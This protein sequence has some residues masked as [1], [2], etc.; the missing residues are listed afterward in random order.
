MPKLTAKVKGKI[1]SPEASLASLP[2]IDGYIA[3]VWTGTAR[4]PVFYKGA[5]KERVFEN[6]FLEYGSMVSMTAPTKRKL[7]FL[8]DPI[9]DREHDWADYKRNYEATFVAKLMYP[10]VAD[11][12]VMPWPERIYTRPYKIANSAE[13]VLIPQYYSTQMQVMINSLNSIQ[14]SD[15]KVSGINSIG[16]LMGNSLMFQSFPSHNGYEDPYFSNFYGQTV[17]LLKN[18]IP[19]QTVHMENLSYAATLKDIEVLVVSYSNMKPNGPEVHTYIADWVRRGGVLVYCGRDNDPYQTVLEW[20]NSKGSTFKSPAEHLF[21]TLGIQ[22]S[23]TENQDFKV[24]KG[25]VHVIRKNPKEFVMEKAG[26]Q[27]LLST[28]KLAYERDAKA[29]PLVFKNNLV[30]HRGPYDIIAVMDESF[31]SEP[32]VIKDLVI[33]LF[34]PQLPILDGK[35]IKPG[36]QAY[37]FNLS[38]L[39]NRD[40]PQ[41]L[42]TAARIYKEEATK[43]TYS[44]IAKSPI[45]TLNSMRVLLPKAYIKVLAT[46]INDNEIKGVKTTWDERSHTAYLGFPN[47]PEGVKVVISW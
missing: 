33:N 10:T 6:A 42:A 39:K 30:L 35:T 3:Q 25:A 47:T 22:T 18:G 40:K 12:E 15:N 34:D 41:V 1:V 8:T 21:K 29:G 45:N 16:V 37:L 7:F 19:V 44:F 24:G 38:R 17:P 11:Y 14:V 31:D 32:V 36:E 13:Q 26:D 46:D 4:E 2:G 5:S 20:W 9:E 23:M 43:S 28:I 27:I